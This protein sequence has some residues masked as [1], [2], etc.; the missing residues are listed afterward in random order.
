MTHR[1]DLKSTEELRVAG[2]PP[3]RQVHKNDLQETGDGASARLVLGHPL[4]CPWGHPRS[5]F[6]KAAASPQCLREC[7]TGGCME[8]GADVLVVWIRGQV[9]RGGVARVVVPKDEAA[10]RRHILVAIF[11]SDDAG[12]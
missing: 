9:P 1:I 10:I 11:K 6:T 8:P 4:H 7:R 3:E 12:T 5:R 2:E